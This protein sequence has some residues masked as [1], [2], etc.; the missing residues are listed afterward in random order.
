M[1]KPVSGRPALLAPILL[2]VA[3]SAEPGDFG[4]HPIGGAPAAPA[5]R[6][7]LVQ[8]VIGA[9]SNEHG[10]VEDL[11]ADARA[12]VERIKKFITERS[13]E[14]SELFGPVWDSTCAW[15]RISRVRIRQ[16]E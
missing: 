8:K 15:M 14:K 6:R 3:R 5:G 1:R 4:Q 10:K 16:V 9:V 2:P 7:E 11:V 13:G 12:T